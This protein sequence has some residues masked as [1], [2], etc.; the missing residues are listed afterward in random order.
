MSINIYMGCTHS[1]CVFV[2]HVHYDAQNSPI[3]S[4]AITS[5]R[6]TH[7]STTSA[8]SRNNERGRRESVS[9]FC[10]S[11]YCPYN[12]RERT[13]AGNTSHSFTEWAIIS[14][15][16]ILALCMSSLFVLCAL[17]N[18][19]IMNCLVCITKIFAHI[20]LQHLCSAQYFISVALFVFSEN[21]CN[22]S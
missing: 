11:L 8:G 1:M 10:V 12:P 9:P 5:F 22:R 20:Y 13:P 14:L 19:D 15:N 17:W 6:S 4:F 21:T 7:R 16:P 2:Y 18:I 3:A